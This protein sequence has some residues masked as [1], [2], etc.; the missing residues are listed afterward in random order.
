MQSSQI[1]GTQTDLDQLLVYE[2][3]LGVDSLTADVVVTERYVHALQ[4]GLGVVRQG[5]RAA[6][7]LTLVNQLH[8]TL[9]Q[10]APG[11]FPKG[12]Y[13]QEQAIIGTFGGRPEDAR[14]IPSPPD[15]IDDAMRELERA[16]LQ[17]Q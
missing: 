13:R 9:M 5:G 11:D 14:F 12:A 16:M 3:T 15:R 4:L 2:A 7:D 10:D 8:A 1:E 6:L 17:Y